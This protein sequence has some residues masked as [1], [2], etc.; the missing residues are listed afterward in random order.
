MNFQI[1]IFAIFSFFSFFP[2]TEQEYRIVD[3]EFFILR[4]QVYKTIA[5]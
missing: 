2:P 3:R 5:G 1:L 4:F